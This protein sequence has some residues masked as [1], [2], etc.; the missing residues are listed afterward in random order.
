L[1]T[2]LDIDSSGLEKAVNDEPREKRIDGSCPSSCNAESGFILID[3]QTL[4]SIY[5]KP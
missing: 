4:I 3:Q 2:S 1:P 5:V